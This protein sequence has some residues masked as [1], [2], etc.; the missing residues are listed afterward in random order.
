MYLMGLK[1]CFTQ[2]LIMFLLSLEILISI[3]WVGK[4]I[5]VLSCRMLWKDANKMFWSTQYNGQTE[6]FGVLPQD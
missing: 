4:K 3:Y 2:C 1:H 6:V 5:W